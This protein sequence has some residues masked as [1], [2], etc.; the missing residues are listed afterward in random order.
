MKSPSNWQP[1]VKFYSDQN[2]GRLTR[3]GVFE[4]NND[5][6]NDYW[7]EDGLPLIAIGVEPANGDNSVEIM[8]GDMTHEVED[9]IKLTFHLT[10]SGYEDGLDIL[11]RN[12]RVTILRFEKVREEAD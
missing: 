10:S 5:V 1:F 2:A 4:L 6:V 7:L 12:N 11:D 9:A 8:V 3:L